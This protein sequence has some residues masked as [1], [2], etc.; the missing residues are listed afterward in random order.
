[1][2]RTSKK[3]NKKKNHQKQK[4]QALPATGHFTSSNFESTR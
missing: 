4:K 2:N 1:V 3:K